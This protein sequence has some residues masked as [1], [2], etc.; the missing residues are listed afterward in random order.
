MTTHFRWGTATSSYQIEG[1]VFEGNRGVSIWDTF[2]NTPGKVFNGDTGAVA[3]DHYNRFPEDIDLMKDLGVD[4]YRF[5]IAWPRIFPNNDGK[6]EQAGID[7]YNKII[8][9]LIAQE[10][11]P[12][13][14]L[15]HW[16][17]PQY[18]EDKG[19][20]SNRETAVAFEAFAAACA[21]AF[22]DRVTN[23]ITLNEPWCT[24]FLGYFAGT[25]APG[26]TS[27]SESIAAA[28]H[29][30]IAHGLGLRAIKSQSPTAE[31]GLTVNMTNYHLESQAPYLLKVF[32]LLDGLQN[33]W[34]IDAFTEG[35]YPADLVTEFGEHLSSV[36]VPGDENI[37]KVKT[38]FLGIN[39]YADGFIGAPP[40]N[41]PT[42]AENS[43]YPLDYAIN[44]DMPKSL[45]VTKTDFGWPVTPEGLGNLL[46]RVHRDWPE[47][48]SIYVTENG[49]AYNDVPNLDGIIDD[50]RRVDYLESHV[51][52]LNRALANG[53]PVKGYFAWSL[54]DNFEWAEGYSK[55]F[56][57]IYVNFDTQERIPK[58][59]FYTYNK[60]IEANRLA[61]LA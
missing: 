41:A 22:G 45:Y 60:M 3:I 11:E 9:A 20:W 26:K 1:A 59:S 37:L 31:V 48:E 46:E 28:H 18:L 24:A 13:I 27:R 33:R 55:R 54:L 58:A 47:I 39:F 32:N 42:L 23:W 17:L 19:G 16:D 52:S 43:P 2:S 44:G 8:D 40:P 51:S 7:F 15:Y 56:G 35:K 10:I 34:W 5:S 14:T 49:A 12:M 30:A 21:A 50:Q 29:T 57:L 6:V 4:S 25:H 61:N 38:D 36:F 53:V